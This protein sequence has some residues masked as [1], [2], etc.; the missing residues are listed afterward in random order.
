MFNNVLR[1]WVLYSVFPLTA[2]PILV[3]YI[4]LPLSSLFLP[5]RSES[6]DETLQGILYY[7]GFHFQHFD[8]ILFLELLSLC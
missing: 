2:F 1:L 6:I 3:I 4:D 8:L 5:H 7:R